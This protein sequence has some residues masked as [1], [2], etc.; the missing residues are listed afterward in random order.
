MIVVGRRGDNACS[1]LIAGDDEMKIINS[2]VKLKR[3]ARA[4]GGCVICL[5]GNHEIMN[6]CGV[7]FNH[8]WIGR[9]CNWILICDMFRTL[10]TRRNREIQDSIRLEMKYFNTEVEAGINLKKYPKKNSLVFELELQHLLL[11]VFSQKDF[12]VFQS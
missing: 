8:K 12:R 5:L 3:E 4:A 10:G 11:G 1:Y 9:S 7:S 2:L 6:V